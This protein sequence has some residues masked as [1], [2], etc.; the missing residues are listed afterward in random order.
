MI[1][2]VWYDTEMKMIDDGFVK[3][4]EDLK[5]FQMTSF[6]LLVDLGFGI[7]LHLISN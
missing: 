6:L 2:F 7:A 4:T 1:P 5:K 3:L